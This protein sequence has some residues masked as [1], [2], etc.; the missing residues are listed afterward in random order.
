MS[1]YCCALSNSYALVRKVGN[2]MARTPLKS[3]LG[4]W[5]A[6][7]AS[8]APESRGSKI[9]RFSGLSDIRVLLMLRGAGEQ[10][11]QH[12]GH[13]DALVND[14]DDVLGD[15]RGDPV[16]AREVE[17]RLAGLDAFGGL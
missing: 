4:V 8:S 7:V 5:T 16:G 2:P 15:R 3:G 10:R 1:A 6:R 17:D 14:L 12:V 11:R 9:G 13:R